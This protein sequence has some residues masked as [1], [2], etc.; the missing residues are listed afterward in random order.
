MLFRSPKPLITGRDLMALG[1]APGP[2]YSEILDAVQS[3]QLEG[4]LTTPEA[5]IE[6]VKAEYVSAS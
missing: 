2:R 3:R 6:W 5:A 4:T 1:L